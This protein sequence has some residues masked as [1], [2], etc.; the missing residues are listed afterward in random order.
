MYSMQE[1]KTTKQAKV[2]PLFTIFE[3]HLFHS[4][5]EEIDRQSFVLGVVNEYVS[6]LRK[7]NI[8]VPAHLEKFIVEELSLQVSQMLVKKIY[9]YLSIK[10]YQSQIPDTQKK[11]AKK[12][13]SRIKRASR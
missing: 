8:A 6:Y 9:G 1:P 12:S 3:Q 7:L 5:N 2:D 10:D 4:Q 13:Y 11:R